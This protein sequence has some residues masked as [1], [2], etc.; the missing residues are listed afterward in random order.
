MF[1]PPFAAQTFLPTRDRPCWEIAQHLKTQLNA[2]YQA[3]AD[4]LENPITH[5]E[6]VVRAIADY[7]GWANN[8]D[9]FPYLTCYRTTTSGEYLERVSATIAYYLPSMAIQDECPGILRWVELRIARHLAKYS[10]FYPPDESIHAHILGN[11]RGEYG[12]GVLPG[13]E[14]STFPFIR[15]NF[16]FQ[17]LGV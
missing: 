6:P 15:I 14:V 2:D 8:F 3:I 9:E 17:E 16:D 4:Q 5:P 10:D 7:N 12:I 1:A 13:S 11:L